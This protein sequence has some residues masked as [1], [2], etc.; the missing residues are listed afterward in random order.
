MSLESTN[1][2]VVKN[3]KALPWYSQPIAVLAV[4][5]DSPLEGYMI[6]FDLYRGASFR[7]SVSY[8][9]Q[10]E[11]FEAEDQSEHHRLMIENS[12]YAKSQWLEKEAEEL[13]V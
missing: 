11:V 6:M 3:Y 7:T 9:E 5:V 12:N 1:N 10:V 2:W 13:N 8:I 4:Q